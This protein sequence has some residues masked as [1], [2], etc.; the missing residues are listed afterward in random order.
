MFC[1]TNTGINWPPPPHSSPITILQI[2]SKPKFQEAEKWMGR[3]WNTIIYLAG[4]PFIWL[5]STKKHQIS[6]SLASQIEHVFS[7]RLEPLTGVPSTDQAAFKVC[8]QAA[9]GKWRVFVCASFLL[10][11]WSHSYS[12]L[13][14]ATASGSFQTVLLVV[15]LDVVVIFCQS[16]ARFHRNWN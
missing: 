5:L 9:K 16:D 6:P 4:S 1:Y 2:M 11:C 15:V 10:K 3:T 12:L 14:A 7:E 13:P 8:I